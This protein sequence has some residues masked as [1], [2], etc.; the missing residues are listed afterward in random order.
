MK[1]YSIKVKNGGCKEAELQMMF[2]EMTRNGWQLDKVASAGSDT[3]FNQKFVYIFSKD[4]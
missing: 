2:D 1:Q 3:I 4:N